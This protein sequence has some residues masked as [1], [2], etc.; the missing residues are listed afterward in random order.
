MYAASCIYCCETRYGHLLTPKRRFSHLLLAVNQE[1]SRSPRWRRASHSWAPSSENPGPVLIM[2]P[3]KPLCAFWSVRQSSI[4][5]HH[6]L[7]ILMLPAP[8][9]RLVQLHKTLILIAAGLGQGQFG[10]KE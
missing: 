4:C 3:W 6:L 8:A 5:L 10:A 9:E 1:K 2:W 7:G